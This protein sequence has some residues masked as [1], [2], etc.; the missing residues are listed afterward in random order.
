M[1]PS[2]LPLFDADLSEPPARGAK[3]RA[4]VPVLLPLA[5]DEP[6]TYE[7]PDGETLAPGDFVVVP[8][9][10]MKRIGVVWREASARP[11]DPKKLKPVL[12]RLDEVPPLP[13]LNLAF[14]D[15]VA[16][17]TL[18]PRGMV[19]RMMMSARL[20]FEAEEP[21]FGFRASSGVP[22]RMTEARQRV[23]AAVADGA[24]WSKKKLMDAAGVSAAVIDGL[25][26]AGALVRAEL[27]RARALPPKPDFAFASLTDAQL[28]AADA[29]RET[30]A[31][32]GFSATLLDGVTG[33]GKTE[34][35]FE[36]VA[37]ALRRGERQVLILLPE[38]ALTNQFLERFERRFGCRPCEW[39]SAVS[40]KERARVWRG[41]AL[42]E[43]RVVC[44]ARSA[45]FLP[46]ADLGLIVVDEEHDPSFKQ[47]DRVTYQAR[48]MAVVRASLG[49]IPI[50]L[51]SATPS[52]ESV[53]NVQRGRYRHA[54]LPGRFSGNAL[55]DVEAVDL[56]ATP[57]ER[58][59]WISEPLIGAVNEALAK[60]E[61]ALLFLNRRGYAPLTLCRACG[62]RFTCPQCTA[63]L[64]EH[65][66]RGRLICHHCGF[67]LPFPKSCP[68]CH[69]EGTL[70]AS[71]PG[72]ER[73]TEEAQNRWPEARLAVLSSDLVP[74]TAVLREI[75]TRITEGDVD[76]VVGT[77][78]VSKGHNFPKLSF[79]GV[80]DGDLSLATADPRAGERTFQ[81]LHQVTGR[82]GR[83]GAPGRGLIQTHFPD[84]PVM[85]A[86]VSGD[87]EAFYE[88]E[89]G[90][91]E[92][93]G[94]PPFGRLAALI[95]S[96]KTRYDAE[97]FARALAVAAPEAS[98]IQVLGPV[99]APLAIIRGLHRQRL[100]VKA[101]REA[102]LQAYLRAWLSNVDAPRGGVTLHIDVDP[103]SFL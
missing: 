103:H 10:P 46:F 94:Y 27:P 55:P 23:M 2:D 29:L 19:L 34:V 77:Q 89:I 24:V 90:L 71:G 9:G 85:R 11:V 45:L 16:Q 40:P 38:I 65:R 92:E 66:L 82:A 81:L 88:A 33:S 41:V 5:L 3:A 13:P 58:G 99:E 57:P 97:G 78:L 74:S 54:I 91:R 35:Y 32:G 60:G 84:H 96:G 75:L 86:L 50:V 79:V 95:V 76:I 51:A 63:Y 49:K 53:V 61:Q 93:A 67:S 80:V 64:V 47:D 83:F 39:H 43:V 25:A 52:V 59:T 6:Y 98:R 17:Y 37:E 8:L 44:G 62:H 72:I 14:A 56:R 1:A 4:T 100:L 70:A 26:E 31:D 102:D 28:T 20:V 42:G 36:A 7:V 101:A 22:S 48:D 87:R 18:A 21:R 30:I 68:S 15:W 69:G 73:V 12:A